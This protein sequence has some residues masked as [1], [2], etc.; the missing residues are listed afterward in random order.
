MNIFKRIWC[1][2]IGHKPIMNKYDSPT[3]YHCKRCG[4]KNCGSD[5]YRKVKNAKS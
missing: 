1:F 3:R 4:K 2:L 5:N